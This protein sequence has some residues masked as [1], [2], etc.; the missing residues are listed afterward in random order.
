MNIKILSYPENYLDL[1]YTAGRN[2]YGMRDAAEKQESTRK[3]GAFTEK[4]IALGH[5]SVLEHINII[6]YNYN[7]SRSFLAQITRHRLVAFSVKSQHYVKHTDFKY[8]NLETWGNEPEIAQAEYHELMRQINLLYQYYITHGIPHY[9][10][11]EILP[12]ACLTDIVMTANVREWRHIIQQRI[13]SNNTPEIQEWAKVMLR[14][15][16]LEMPELFSDLRNKYES[17]L[18][19]RE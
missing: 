17:L 19:V 11:R 12:N 3:I 18:E 9:I 7:V 5:E 4:L 15:L 1:I 2:C 10:A 8:K 16:Y 6:T 13:T 14:T